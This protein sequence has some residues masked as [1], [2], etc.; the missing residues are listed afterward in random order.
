MFTH[1]ISR[2]YANPVGKVVRDVNGIHIKNLRHLV[3]TLRDSKGKYTRFRFADDFSDVL[4]FD[5]NDLER[6]TGEIMEDQGIAPARRGSADVLKIW[7]AK[8]RVGR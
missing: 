5:K 2:G 7:Q 4:V 3:E 1:K 8:G 6:A